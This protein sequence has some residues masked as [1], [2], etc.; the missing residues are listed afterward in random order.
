MTLTFIDA[1]F[2]IALRARTTPEHAAAVA[3]GRRLAAERTLLACTDLVFAEV[4]AY[5][6]RMVAL[7]EQVINDF[8]NSSIVRFQ[9]VAYNDKTAAIELLRQHRDKTYSYCDAVSFTVMRRQKI[10]RVASFDV[11]FRQFG[12]FEVINEAE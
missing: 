6:S 8:W 4:H 5:F 10:R 12:E 9:E 3:I 2:W 7:R 11:H 1:S